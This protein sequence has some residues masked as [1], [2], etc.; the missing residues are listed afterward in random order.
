MT[1]WYKVEPTEKEVESR[2]DPHLK[3]YF[4]LGVRD[5]VRKFLRGGIE[6]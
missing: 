1:V 6:Y 4:N 5:M 2:E 3:Y